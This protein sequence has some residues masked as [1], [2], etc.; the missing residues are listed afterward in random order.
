MEDVFAHHPEGNHCEGVHEG[1]TWILNHLD[2]GFLSG[3]VALREC[4][5]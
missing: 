5:G 1:W 4:T 3:L 2:I